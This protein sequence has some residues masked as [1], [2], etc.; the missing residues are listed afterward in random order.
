MKF[1]IK[2]KEIYTVSTV[3]NES[4]K[5]SKSFWKTLKHSLTRLNTILDEI[6]T[7]VVAHETLEVKH[8]KSL[9]ELKECW[10]V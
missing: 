3:E 2:V 4:F 8:Q 9:I 7:D 5:T 6:M 10:N 1:F